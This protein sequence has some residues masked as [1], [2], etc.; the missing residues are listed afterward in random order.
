MGFFSKTITDEE[1]LS[2]SKPLYLVSF[3]LATAL[4]EAVSN[5]SIEDGIT[6]V[7][8]AFS[9]LPVIY[10]S[11]KQL[12]DPTSSEARRAHKYFKSALKD[13]AQ[14]IKQGARFFESLYGG[15]G[16]RLSQGGIVRRAAAGRLAFEKTIFEEFIKSAEKSMEKTTAYFSNR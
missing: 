14:G 7:Q 5:D 9:K 8:D 3:P 11:L 1:W 6:A 4:N 16:D 2:Q 15:P 10:E 12:S 13:Y